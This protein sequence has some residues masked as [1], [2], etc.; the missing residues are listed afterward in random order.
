VPL[1]VLGGGTTVL[2]FAGTLWA[3]GEVENQLGE[4]IDNYKAAKDV[5]RQLR[6][7]QYNAVIR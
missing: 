7:V 3:I 6:D 4:R 1:L 2:S 5:F